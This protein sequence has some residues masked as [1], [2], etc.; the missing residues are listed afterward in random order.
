MRLDGL[1]AHADGGELIEWL[2]A[3]NL[4]PR[5]VFVT[6]GEPSASD[7]LRRRLTETFGWDAMVPD[8]GRIIELTG[9]A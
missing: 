8:L 4:S 1:S 6:H 9:R 2:R 5:Q 7:T 3:S